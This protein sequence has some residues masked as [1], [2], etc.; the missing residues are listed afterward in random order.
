[1]KAENTP[2]NRMVSPGTMLVAVP[3]PKTV[4]VAIASVPNGASPA[5]VAL[6]PAV[7]V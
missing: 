4:I 5:K 1:V 7:G 2:V 3:N 6:V